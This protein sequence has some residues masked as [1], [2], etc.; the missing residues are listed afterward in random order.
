MSIEQQDKPQ[1]GRKYL[2]RTYLIKDSFKM[3]KELLKVKNKK[4]TWLKKWAKDL[5]RH[6]TKEDIWQ[7]STQKDAP[8]LVSSGKFKFKQQWD[9]STG[10]AKIWNIDNTKRCQGWG[11][12]RT[13]IHCWWECRMIWLLW[14]AVWQFFVCFYKTKHTLTIQSS[15]C[16]PWYLPKG[17]ENVCPH[18]GLHTGICS[19]SIHNCQNL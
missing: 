4:T 11:A 13:L 7:I 8:H 17:D 3:Y 16:T 15:Y 5:N 14:N 9:M 12:T 19:S 18:K 2:H 1:T 6:L 10:M